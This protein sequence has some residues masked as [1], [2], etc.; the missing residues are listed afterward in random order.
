M[1]FFIIAMG[2]LFS[3]FSVLVLSYISMATMVGP[4]IAP[5]LVLFGHMIFSLKRSKTDA[6]WQAVAWMQAIG[7]GGGI[8]D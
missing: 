4:W 7:A 8:T 5:T 6:D 1:Q 3:L 2:V